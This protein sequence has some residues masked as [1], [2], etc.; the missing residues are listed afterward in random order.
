MKTIRGCTLCLVL[1]SVLLLLAGCASRSEMPESGGLRVLVDGKA[2]QAGTQ[3][4]S[5][6]EAQVWFTL[7]G[8]LLLTLPFSEAH[9]V[10]ILQED[11]SENTVRMTGSAVYMEKVNCPH[12]DCVQMGEVTL[13]NLEYRPLGGF[14]V[15]L[16]HRLTVEV[17]EHAD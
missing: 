1:L 15:C 8:N 3:K 5:P 9:E 10:S 4:A 17:R 14:L 7:E 11:G 16:P 6:E 12:E 2:V 13:E